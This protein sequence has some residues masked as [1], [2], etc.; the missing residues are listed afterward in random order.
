M[1]LILFAAGCI[2]TIS[3]YLWIVF[4]KS[5]LN[6]AEYWFANKLGIDVILIIA[7]CTFIVGTLGLFIKNMVIYICHTAKSFLF[8][9]EY[10]YANLYFFSLCK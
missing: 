5:N 8:Y 4:S 6:I 9:T 3:I 1:K 7:I 2:E 10:N